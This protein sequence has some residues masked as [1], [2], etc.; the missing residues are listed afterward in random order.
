MHHKNALQFDVNTRLYT[1]SARKGRIDN[2]LW[3]GGKYWT[4]N[5]EIIKTVTEG[6][7][8]KGKG[9]TDDLINDL[10]DDNNRLLEY[11][12]LERIRGFS[13]IYQWYMKLCSLFSRVSI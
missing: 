7:W 9:Y 8:L 2:G 13:A 4:A 1:T 5:Q 10:K 3:A 6:K 11:K 12:R